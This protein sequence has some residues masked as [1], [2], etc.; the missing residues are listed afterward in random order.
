MEADLAF[1]GAVSLKFGIAVAG[2]L[3]HVVATGPGEVDVGL[4]VVAIQA[5]LDGAEDEL[6]RPST[7]NWK[8]PGSSISMNSASQSSILV[9]RHLP[10]SG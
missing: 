3:V 4:T 2:R 1:E 7:S 6:P 9:I 5:A 8:Y 10:I